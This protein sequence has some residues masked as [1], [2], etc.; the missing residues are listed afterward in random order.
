MVRAAARR[1]E[2]LRTCAQPPKPKFNGDDV[3]TVEVPDRRGGGIGPFACLLLDP[4]AAEPAV[5]LARLGLLARVARLRIV[6]L[7][8]R[9]GLQALQA[10][11][12]HS[13]EGDDAR[14]FSAT[15]PH[16]PFQ[17]GRPRLPGLLRARVW[18]IDRMGRALVS[19]PERCHHRS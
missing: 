8:T 11:W 7:R 17:P 10:K 1:Y 6:H 15:R 16:Q 9:P 19:V 3:G 4:A 12:K 13:A 14:A 18:G 2:R 5:P